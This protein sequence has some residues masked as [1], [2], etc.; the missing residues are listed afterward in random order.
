MMIARERQTE[1]LVELMESYDPPGEPRL[2]K[3]ILGKSFKPE[4]NI[5]IGSPAILLKNLLEERGHDVEMYDPYVDPERPLPGYPPSIFLIATRHPDFVDFDFPQG[6]VVVD[7]WRCIPHRSGV[8]IVSV[9]R[10]TRDLEDD[11]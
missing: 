9:G 3:V 7:P 10:M 11:A 2:L 1:W 5:T 6:S 8:R 4:T